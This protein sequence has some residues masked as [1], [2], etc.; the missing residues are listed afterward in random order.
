VK[1]EIGQIYQDRY[2]IRAELGSG[3]MGTVY[4]A[5]QI[6]AGRDV[7][8]KILRAESIHDDE[9][10]ARFYREFKLL[11]Q[12][13]HPHIMT[14]Y[15]LALDDDYIPFAICEFIDGISLRRVILD[16]KV[17]WAAAAKITIQICQAVQYAHERGI[18]HRDLKPENVLI[19][20][21]PEPNYVKLIDFGLSRAVEYV[22][23]SQKLTATGF[24][25]GSPQY[26]SPEQITGKATAQSD[27]YAIGC[28]LYEMLSGDALFQADSATGLIY[29]QI[30]EDPTQQLKSLKAVPGSLRQLLDKML[31][32]KPE[33]RFQSCAEVIAAL[34]AVLSNPNSQT[35]ETS[36]SPKLLGG[37]AALIII[38]GGCIF[39]LFNNRSAVKPSSGLNGQNT[40]K[41][42]RHLLIRSQMSLMEGVRQAQILRQGF[43]GRDAAAI[44]KK[45]LQRSDVVEDVPAKNAVLK[46]LAY[47]YS[48]N[49]QNDLAIETMQ[50]AIDALPERGAPLRIGSASEL[51]MLW[52]KMGK[53]DKAKQ[54]YKQY[55]KELDAVPNAQASNLF[56]YTDYSRLLFEDHK[57]NEAYVWAKK[58]VLLAAH[59]VHG[60]SPTVSDRATNNGVAAAWNYYD[61]CKAIGKTVEGQKQLDATAHDLKSTAARDAYTAVAITAFGD[62]AAQ[63]GF[64]DQAKSMYELAL[65]DSA[66]LSAL[67]AAPIRSRC[68]SDLSRMQTL[69]QNAKTDQT[70]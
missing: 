5:T 58:A 41:A 29:K 63:H 28:I 37:V 40:G 52:Q 65:N 32:K 57:P 45:A 33:D 15:G 35:R 48:T 36:I 6:D 24:L 66:K 55:I 50:S 11:S 23:E 8:L 27:I 30:N 44:L 54:V 38:A 51:A 43:R 7:A 68:N 67:E 39:N 34:E 69:R 14:L 13:S 4:S 17:S 49:G 53:I 10:I 9:S 47:C 18:L 22:D 1:P 16:K 61:I 20:P 3:G 25:V 31:R 59:C 56:I 12:L 62:A 26:M 46:E 60:W 19:L 64:Y 42:Q 70:Q 21:F 2:L